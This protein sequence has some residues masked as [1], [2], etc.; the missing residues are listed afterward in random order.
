[1]WIPVT[2]DLP[3][4]AEEVIVTWVNHNPVPYYAFV[5]DIPL[6]GFAVYY[7]GNWYWWTSVAQDLLEEYG[8]RLEL[9]DRVDEAIEITAWMPLPEPYGREEE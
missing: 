1:M 9:L 3:D 4:D 6:T 7:R 2:A 8:D 5:K